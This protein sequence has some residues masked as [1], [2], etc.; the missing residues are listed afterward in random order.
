[1]VYNQDEGVYSRLLTRNDYPENFY[2]QLLVMNCWL[3]N[4]TLDNNITVPFY[5]TSVTTGF[6]LALAGRAEVRVYD[7]IVVVRRMCLK[8]FTIRIGE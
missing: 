8:F 7:N 2:A 6:L 1:M 4:N 3:F 5:F